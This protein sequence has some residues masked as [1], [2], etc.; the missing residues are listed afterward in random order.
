[1]RASRSVS[2]KLSSFNMRYA[3]APGHTRTHPHPC[4]LTECGVP[5]PFARTAHPVVQPT[6]ARTLA[7]ATAPLR[8][9]ARP[10][11]TARPAAAHV[12][13]RGWPSATC[14]IG[15]C[16]APP[17]ATAPTD[18]LSP[19][20]LGCR[21]WKQPAGGS[22][23]FSR[24]SRR[25]GRASCTPSKP[26]AATCDVWRNVVGRQQSELELARVTRVNRPSVN[27]GRSRYV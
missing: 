24:T 19:T 13:P 12:Y 11:A 1:M 26:F 7:G 6:G 10:A 3:P 14:T 27:V 5:I 8:A 21:I 9:H 15:W 25:D 17:P 2:S 18:V 22:R 23:V 4:M 20:W 16:A